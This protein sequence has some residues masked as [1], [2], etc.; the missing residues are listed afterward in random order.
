MKVKVTA[1]LHEESVE[2]FFKLVPVSKRS[3]IVRSYLINDYTLSKERLQSDFSIEKQSDENEMKALHFFLNQ[4]AI[5]KLD[6]V[7]E[8]LSLLS[9]ENYT[10]TVEASRSRVL[11]VIVNQINNKYKADP[12]PKSIRKNRVFYLPISNKKKLLK[13]IN[14]REVTPTIEDFIDKEYEGPNISVDEL[15]QRTK[16]NM[17]LINLSLDQATIEELDEYAKK[18]N[19]KRSHIFRNVVAELIE[20]FEQGPV[21]IQNQLYPQL[22][23]LV[24]EMKEF[25]T[26]EEIQEAIMQYQVKY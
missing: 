12:I 13:Y 4:Q 7:V 25:A 11:Q 5:R 22:D 21:N 16:E 19:V 23:Q 10:D 14:A 6:S 8:S 24:N 1:Y 20:K 9:D 3:R 15:K 26:E 2:T 17:E 18:S